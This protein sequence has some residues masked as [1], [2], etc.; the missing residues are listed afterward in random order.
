MLDCQIAVSKKSCTS[1]SYFRTFFESDK[2]DAIHDLSHLR[3][4]IKIGL[5]VDDS[6]RLSR[7]LLSKETILDETICAQFYT[8]CHDIHK[9]QL[10]EALKSHKIS[11]ARNE[12]IS[13]IAA[14][15]VAYAA[16]KIGGAYSNL[17]RETL[18]RWQK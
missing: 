15:G 4:E 13:T 12:Y 11:D 7:V 2:C 16:V 3:E 17:I 5:N 14:I 18:K 10:V 1:A 6:N 8:K 9:M